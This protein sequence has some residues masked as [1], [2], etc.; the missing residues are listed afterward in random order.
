M[1]LNEITLKNRTV[2]LVLAVILVFAGA[3]SYSTIPKESNP[4]IEIPI[5]IVNTIYPGISP[6]DMEALV[7][8][9]IER[10]LQGINGVKDIRST[11]LESVSSVVVE[12]DLDVSNIEAS[13]RVRERVDIARA[14][15]PP[16][17][18]EPIIIEIDLDDFPILTVNLAADYPLSR[19]TEVANR[20]SDMLET[21]SGV[22][23]VDMI[24]DVEREVQV[25]VDI[26]ALNSFGIPLQAL[27]GA[28]QGQNLTIPGGTIDVDRM[29]YLIRIS[30][31][32]DDP[33]EINDLVIVGGGGGG[34]GPAPEGLV[35]MRDVAEVIFGFKDRESFARLRSYKVNENGELVDLPAEDIQDLEVISLNIKKRPAANILE[36]VEAV[37]AAVEDYP[38]P[39]GTQVVIT[40]DQSED[41]RNLISDLENS[42]ISGML[43]VVLVLVFFLGIRNALLVGTAVPLSIL[44]GF[45]VL[46]SLGYTAN[47]VILF[48]LIIALGLL[49]DNSIVVVENIYRYREMGYERFEAAKRG[50]DEVG[51]ALI[52]ATSTLL[53]AFIPMTFWPGIIGQF[54]GYLPFTLIVVLLCSLFIALVIYP[55]LTAYLVKLDGEESRP[56][57]KGFKMLQ[58][59]LGVFLV[60]AIGMANPVTLLVTVLVALFF[61]LTF[62][63]M[64]KP[65]S[66]VFM[67]RTLPAILDWYRNFLNWMLRRNYKI[68]YAM[69][70]NTFALG[71]LSAG[72]L[73]AVLGA[74]VSI[75]SP[76]GQ[77][78]ILLGGVFAGLG[79]IGIL[80]HFVE[81]MLRGNKYSMYSGLVLAAF[82][83]IILG[84]VSLGTEVSL[85]VWVTLM[86]LPVALVILGG[87]GLLIGT[88]TDKP[89]LV[90]DNRALL[91]NSVLG[92]MVS[93]FFLFTVIPT[94][95]E[96]FPE[97]DPNRIIIELE[98]PI[99]MNVHASNATAYDVQQRLYQLIDEDPKVKAN[100]ENI[101]IN[102]GV[103][104]D[105]FFG[106]GN[107]S[108]ELSR[109]TVNLVDYGD[110]AE[111]SAI[112]LRK[113][114]S[115]ITDLPDIIVSIEGEEVGPPTGAPV[116]IEVSGEDFDEVVRI[117]REIT[118]KLIE[119]STTRQ[120]PGLVD[121]RN[122]ISGGL[123]EYRIL[124]DYERANRFG[125]SLADIAQTVRIANNGLEASK[126]RDGEDEYDI[127]VRLREEDRQNL[128]SLAG[129]KIGSPSGL[130]PLVA[131][132]SFEEGTGLGS[133]TRLNL[134]RTATIEGQAESGFSGP[135]VLSQVQTLLADYVADL[136]LGYTVRYT[137]ES[138]DQEEAF[139]FLTTALLV[140]FALIFLIMLAKFNNV[141]SPLIIMTAVG[142]SLIGVLLGL[143]LTR[144]PFG[145]M[146]FIGVISLAGIVCVNNVVLLDYVKQLTEKGM[147]KREAI[148]EAGTIRFR[149]VMLT[150][151]TTILG[152]V[153]LTF[154]INID[155]VG[156]F[157]NLDPNLQ[158]G[159][160]STAFWGPMGIAIISGLTFATFLTLVVVPVLYSAFDSVADRL[161][162]NVY[163]E[164]SADA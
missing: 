97:T 111:P 36:T 134:S 59:G 11:T 130:I 58:Y 132:A 117:T 71:M 101:Q 1:K 125:L 77:L 42:I 90:T 140:G 7:T 135:E 5:F 74:V 110:R 82:I 31:E 149:P 154:G 73:F 93:I 65:L 83:G 103:A 137:G 129:L 37:L 61:V 43:F 85:L 3:Y 141:K 19:L 53:A 84:A 20:M 122:N 158:F 16:D 150:A 63:F 163:A 107:Q 155:Y 54:M 48:S 17:V 153:P 75:L 55:V 39:G 81:I 50:A 159:S 120:I 162:K 21:V 38:L 68:R 66:A 23:E 142:L 24:G 45:I 26:D 161:S 127:V 96:F 115:V 69:L 102:V 92:L 114:R 98:G 44:V 152:L 47:F 164:Q 4:S 108:P 76:A 99:G 121:I 131:V 27:V 14:E 15:L 146:T 147:S 148:V 123:P 70:R 2:I 100:I 57:S 144:T 113:M 13:Q 138:E 56:R 51:Y 89:L 119:A 128:E 87:I 41:V 29:S 46:L 157:A 78:L 40:G 18:E 9:P 95:V 62:K 124:V 94:G 32:F 52:A 10:E 12:F 106:G 160:E 25:N 133:I 64:I 126:W 60:V 30:G 34:E 116:N 105:P 22:R 72:A 109:L 156:L 67:E 112:T 35:Y 151:L 8:Q 49:V 6:A 33:D 145:L 143:I 104:G 86:G 91:L 80:I 28:I 136:P 79:V 139:G 88:R 118:Q